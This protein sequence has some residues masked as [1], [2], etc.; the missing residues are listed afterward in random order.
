MENVVN[1][2]L[3]KAGDDTAFLVPMLLARMM[4][5]TPEMCKGMPAPYVSYP[6]W[7]LASFGPTGR[8]DG[9][10]GQPSDKVVRMMIGALT[11][12]VPFEREYWLRVHMSLLPRLERL[13]VVVNEFCDNARARLD[14][15]ATASGGGG[16][17]G[18]EGGGEGRPP[19]ISI[20]EDA[21]SLA[22]AAKAEHQKTGKVPQTVMAA[23]FFRRAWFMQSLIPAIIRVDGAE[24][25]LIEAMKGANVLPANFTAKGQDS[26]SKAAGKAAT[27]SRV[28]GIA[29]G[30]EAAARSLV[31]EIGSE[32][33]STRSV[34]TAIEKISAL[35]GEGLSKNPTR[36][37]AK[38]VGERLFSV[39]EEA[40]KGSKRALRQ[41]PDVA[42]WTRCFVR[43][44]MAGREDVREAVVERVTTAARTEA[45]GAIAPAL[46]VAHLIESTEDC[47]EIAALWESLPISA[48]DHA[49]AKF[50]FGTAVVQATLACHP[51]VCVAVGQGKEPTAKPGTQP[52]SAVVLPGCLFH[53]LFHLREVLSLDPRSRALV[54]GSEATLGH[55]VFVA[56]ARSAGMAPIGK[57]LEEQ[58]EIG[59]GVLPPT[60]AAECC[61][62]TLWKRLQAASSKEQQRGVLS[63]VLEQVIIRNIS[64]DKP[65]KWGAAMHS[66]LVA[67]GDVSETFS[68]V[69]AGSEWR[70][71]WAW[72]ALRCRSLGSQQRQ[73][74]SSS[75]SSPPPGPCPVCSERIVEAFWISCSALP[76]SAWL[77]HQA[78]S[79]PAVK[80]EL[81][82]HLSLLPHKSA[83]RVVSTKVIS[84]G[85]SGMFARDPT[86]AR[87]FVHEFP[88]IQEAV[89]MSRIVGTKL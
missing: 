15:C 73:Q 30:F 21:E 20:P 24:S 41:V 54:E 60:M 68:G 23:S 81:V 22:K 1:K 49:R 5:G 16:G 63:S 25:A 72:D 61:K 40:V 7:F 19:G 62:Q 48:L 38:N 80:R 89:T 85:L 29:D 66:V 42:T 46:I 57:W 55:P 76:S 35:V 74:S 58:L 52:T 17:G 83:G 88:Q 32:G 14:A 53:T 71:P 69:I 86:I 47:R 77:S 65:G 31:S 75:S 6:N 84:R 18:G 79:H 59:E 45:T 2:L 13:F 50:A 33:S 9:E 67:L 3:G 4:L 36:T 10:Q 44:L 43:S 8:L 11:N 82:A 28:E 87:S 78:D 56:L 37:G 39:F 34:E 64:P 26:G 12:M 27:D 70:V 51:R